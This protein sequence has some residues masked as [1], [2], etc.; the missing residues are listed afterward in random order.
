MPTSS[1][2]TNTEPG[3]ARWPRR[4]ALPLAA[5]AMLATAAPAMAQ[6]PSVDSYG[7]DAGDVLS[8]SDSSGTS[9]GSSLPFTGF[10]ALAIAG[11]GA[12]LVLLGGTLRFVAK[13]DGRNDSTP[14]SA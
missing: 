8:S 2:Q 9:S 13:R 6:D 1:I 10:D 11:G 14:T 7:G 12:I 4:A 5:T 3:R